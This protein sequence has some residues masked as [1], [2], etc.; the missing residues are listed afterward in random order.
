MKYISIDGDDIGRKI[1][2][3]Y[4]SNSCNNLKELSSS[5]KIST[6]KIS[7]HLTSLGFTII[8]CAA[9]GVVAEIKTK[10]DFK[11]LFHEISHLA[12]EG[13]TFS[14]GVGSSLREAYIA[15]MSAKSNGKGC[16]HEYAA[17]DSEKIE[18]HHV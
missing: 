12:P 6:E 18:S 8:F 11:M 3:Y 9:D 1:T 2:S 15:L 7:S 13:I 4:L 14:A 17:L 5:L 16:L 10:M